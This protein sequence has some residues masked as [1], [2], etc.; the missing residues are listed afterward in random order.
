MGTLM[1]YDERA[2]YYAVEHQHTNDHAF[3][4]RLITPEV[5]HI[6]EI[7][8]GVGR[9]VFLL[10]QS[11][12]RVVAVDLEPAMITQLQKRL[13]NYTGLDNIFPRVGNMCTLDLQ[14]HFDLIIVPQE[15][16][17]LLTDQSQ[18]RQALTSLARHLAPD[19]TLMVDL[20]TYRSGRPS[21]AHLHPTYFDP[22]LPDGRLVHEWTRMAPAGTQIE[23]SRI[24]HRL[25]DT[26]ITVE[27]HY[28]IRHTNGETHNRT[29]HIEMR[30]YAY[31][32]FVEM[33]QK[34][35]LAPRA[36]YRNYHAEPFGPDAVRMI[37]LLQHA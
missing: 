35:R 22:T 11:G 21:D 4:T 32:E 27:F 6:L 7:P 12:R 36:I 13:E 18:A 16:F 24:Q 34:S 20:A 37:F 33:A 28:H 25:D 10:A 8:C 23:R 15:A 26:R 2:A 14:E 30:C 1:H 3:L 29:A 31:K 5:N 19:G 9:N 17:Q